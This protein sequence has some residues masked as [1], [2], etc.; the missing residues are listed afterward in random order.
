M[1]THL[2]T[3]N[4]IGDTLKHTEIHAHNLFPDGVT[5]LGVLSRVGDHDSECRVRKTIGIGNDSGLNDDIIILSHL[6]IVPFTFVLALLIDMNHTISKR[7][8]DVTT[9]IK[10]VLVQYITRCD[11]SVS[12]CH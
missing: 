2:L 4:L 12:E 9:F 8:F 1:N 7:P 6:H 10:V 3:A 5:D 11:E